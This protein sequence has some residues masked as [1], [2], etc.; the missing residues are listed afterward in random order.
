MLKGLFPL[1]LSNSVNGLLS[2]RLNGMVR[3]SLDY[4]LRYV[5]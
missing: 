1:F 3:Q 4:S 2:L 5:S